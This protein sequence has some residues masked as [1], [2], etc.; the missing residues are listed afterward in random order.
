MELV[1]QAA[2]DHLAEDG[3]GVVERDGQGAGD[4]GET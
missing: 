2:E 1:D 4:G 3:G